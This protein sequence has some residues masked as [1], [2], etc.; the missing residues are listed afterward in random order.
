MQERQLIQHV[1][2]PLTLF[3]PIDIQSPKRII[4]WFRPHLNL[5]G[6]R[7]FRQMLQGSAQLKVAREVVFPIHTQH[8]LALHTIVVVAFKRHIDCRS[9]IKNALIEYSYLACTVI[10]A[11]VCPLRQPHT[12]CS[13]DH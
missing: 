11:V 2:K 4:K 6:E 1:R 9:G 3:L 8:C 10:H 5:I 7:L 13:Y 12:T